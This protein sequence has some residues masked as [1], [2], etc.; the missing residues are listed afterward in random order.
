M[1]P[2]PEPAPEAPPPHHL[3]GTDAYAPRE[4]AARVQDVG[5]A[6]A[7]LPL[8]TPALLGVLAGAFIGLGSLVFTLVAADAAL[9]FAAQ[10]LLGGL[11]LSL[12]LV[13][14][15][16]AGAELFTGN[17]LPAMAWAARRIG[18]GEV[19]RNWAVALLANLVGAAGV[20][21]LALKAGHGRLNA[22]AVGEA[23]QRIALAK[24]QLSPSGAFFRGVLR[25]VPVC[26][27]V[28]TALAGRSVVGGS[29]PVALVYRVICLRPQR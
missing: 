29:V 26:M 1:P 23:A 8:L 11:V 5:V 9:G 27:A 15:T 22:G 21:L 18:T 24:V 19:L 17:D 20:A 3:F 6:K 10:R 14:V 4:I 2:A 7:G 28:W 16:V 13:L 25:I 12:G